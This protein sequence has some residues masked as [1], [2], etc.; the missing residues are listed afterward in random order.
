MKTIGALALALSIVT[1]GGVTPTST[2][3]SA[4]LDLVLSTEMTA[5]VF[6][7]ECH[8]CGGGHGTSPEWGGYGGGEHGGSCLSGTCD[9]VHGVCCCA[10]DDAFDADAALAQAEALRQAVVGN[11]AGAL[12][13]LISADESLVRVVA[14]R[15]SAQI[16][17]CSGQPVANFPL[18]PELLSAA[19]VAQ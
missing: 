3:D 2:T 18:S 16:I 11:D 6:C 12:T 14:E 17:N 5:A 1:I 4:P 13:E 10:E 9:V 15:G 19:S 8:S 7:I